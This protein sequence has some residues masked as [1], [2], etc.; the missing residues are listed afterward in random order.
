MSLTG[1]V[2]MQQGSDKVL[3]LSGPQDRMMDSSK[4]HDLTEGEKSRK[5]ELEESDLC[6]NQQRILLKSKD[7]SNRPRGLARV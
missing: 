7:H 5:K 3:G 1:L 2:E 6:N 4:N